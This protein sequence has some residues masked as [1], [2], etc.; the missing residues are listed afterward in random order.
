MKSV[1]LLFL[2]VAT[3]AAQQKTVCWPRDTAAWVQTHISGK[4]ALGESG[5]LYVSHSNATE[6]ARLRYDLNGLTMSGFTISG[7]YYSF[8][9]GLQNYYYDAVT[10]V[11]N[12]LP[13]GQSPSRCLPFGQG[14]IPVDI[15]GN[16]GWIYRW[17][18]GS[19]PGKQAPK[20]EPFGEVMWTQ[21]DGVNTPISAA[22]IVIE[23]S[24]VSQ[25]FANV[26]HTLPAGIFD[27]PPACQNMSKLETIPEGHPIH[28]RFKG[29]APHLFAK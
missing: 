9:N 14:N 29:I 15:L 13:P 27:L 11:C 18:S 25:V 28:I 20:G 6:A 2:C 19:S 24:L 23:D 12:Y 17:G 1:L 26:T 5:T 7:S 3:I 10:A 21:L 8:A 22:M 16:P 4:D